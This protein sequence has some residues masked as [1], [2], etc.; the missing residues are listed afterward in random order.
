MRPTRQDAYELLQEGVQTLARVEGNGMRVD[1]DWTRKAARRCLRRAERLRKKIEDSPEGRVWVKRYG[2]ATNFASGDQLAEILFQELG[3]EPIDRTATGKPSTDE[4]SIAKL[5]VSFVQ[6]YLRM[7]KY[8]KAEGTYLRNFVGE[9]VDG[10]IH[11]NFNLHTVQT[12]RSSSDR[13]NFQ[14]L[15]I[16]DPEIG[17]IIRRGILS[18]PGR[19]IVEIDYSGIEVRIAAC[20]HRDPTMRKYIEDPTTD[21]H[22]DMAAQIYLLETDEVS[23]KVRYCAKNMF[24]FP[25]FYGSWFPDCARNLW[26]AVDR[27]DLETASGVKIR[28]HLE[29]KG[30]KKLGKCNKKDDPRKGT[31]EKHIQTVEK[32]F[33]GRRFQVYEQWK[34]DWVSTYQERGWFDTLTG[35]RLSGYYT[36]NETINYPVQGSAFH[37]LLWSLIELQKELDARGMKTLLTGQIHDSI[38]ADVPEEETDDYL[39]IAREIMTERLRAYWDWIIVPIDIEAETTPVGGSWFEK[40][41]VPL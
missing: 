27:L 34:K 35:F 22:R 41:E 32:D 10:F 14:N 30:I 2:P 13:P 9:E 20:Y 7:K 17:E 19:R 16:R 23:K 4:S 25:Q 3:H 37:C 18:R 15:P 12:F 11:P 29:K 26:E 31:F 1:L 8:L 36:R 38:V 28:D 21:M 40:K 39:E 6:D 24:V 33:W 5:D